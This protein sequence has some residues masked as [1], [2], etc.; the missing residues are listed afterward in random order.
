VVSGDIVVGREVV[1]LLG[2]ATPGPEPPA[3]SPPADS[4]SGVEP[5]AP[6]SS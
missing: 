1:T 3:D 6:R 4:P 2:R 5:E